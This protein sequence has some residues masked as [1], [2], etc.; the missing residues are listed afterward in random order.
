MATFSRFDNIVVTEHRTIVRGDQ[1]D[2]SVFRNVTVGET[3][4]IAIAGARYWVGGSGVWSN[5]NTANWAYTS[6]GPGGAHAPKTVNDVFFD[7]NS[8]G[9]V[10]QIPF[11]QVSGT[12]YFHDLDCNG[13]TGELQMN[14]PMSC[15]GSFLLSSTMSITADGSGG[16]CT[17]TSPD[18]GE[19]VNF[20]NKEL[21][22]GLYFSGTGGWTFGSDFGMHSV[23]PWLSAIEHSAGT[24]DTGGYDL[25]LNDFT[26]GLDGNSNP[27]FLYLRDSVITFGGNDDSETTG[28]LFGTGGLY[29]DPG[30][31]HVI[32]EKTFTGVPGDPGVSIGSG[33]VI[34]GGSGFDLYDV[35]IRNTPSNWFGETNIGAYGGQLNLH[36][37]TIEATNGPQVV[38]LGSFGGTGVTAETFTIVGGPGENDI[39]SLTGNIDSDSVSIDKVWVAYSNATGAAAPFPVTNSIDFGNNTGWAFP[40]NP[41]GPSV[42]VSQDF[43]ADSSGTYIR[44]AAMGSDQTS[45]AQAT[46]D[47]VSLR[48]L[49]QEGV[50][51]NVP[52]KEFLSGTTDEGREIIFRADT[53]PIQLMSEFETYAAPLAIVTKLQRGSLVKCFVALGDDDFYELEGNA[54]KGVSLTKVHSRNKVDLETPPLARE[55]RISWR[56]SSKQLCRLTQGGIIFLPTTLSHSE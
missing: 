38:Y 41:V 49:I 55:I 9:G 51:D 23:Y 2:P 3:V 25:F 22:L 18:M 53:H 15:S 47:N 12:V 8:G 32:L 14:G 34:G 44:F 26:S 10:V 27:L 52:V 46:I 56:D 1:L 28:F 48:A 29:I 50:D 17:F 40:S 19:I 31:S 54:T 7:A 45:P 42:L 20:F 6:G 16:Y 4:S 35:T 13:F 11:G 5:T 33:G 39:V 36:S 30:T 37:L 24:L 43:V 21:V